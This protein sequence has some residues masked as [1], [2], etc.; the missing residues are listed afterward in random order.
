MILRSRKGDR[1]K[2]N[3]DKF[4]NSLDQSRISNAKNSNISPILE[5]PE[6]HMPKIMKRGG[7]HNQSTMDHI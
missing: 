7:Y 1:K 2:Q 3:H 5:I 4:S 6:V